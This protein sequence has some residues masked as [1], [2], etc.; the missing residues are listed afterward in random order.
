MT[1]HMM[2]TAAALGIAAAASIPADAQTLERRVSGIS[3]GVVEFNFPS[4]EGVCGDGR[5]W[6]R[7]DG[8]MWHGSVSDATRAQPCERGPV[9]VVLTRAES[10]VVRVQTFAGPLSSEP[11]ATNLG[12]VSAS[13]GA[14]F[15]LSIAERLD[16]RP[17]RDVILPAALA[18]GAAITPR[19]IAIARDPNRARELRRSAISWLPRRVQEPG[20]VGGRELARALADIARDET[21]QQQVRQQAMSSL[22][23]LDAG[24]GYDALESIAENAND[25]WLAREATGVI[26]NSGD[27]RSREF[28]RRVAGSS[29]S[30][31]EARVSALRGLGGGYGTAK[32]AEFLRGLYPRLNGERMRDAALEGIASIG[33]RTNAS[34]LLDIARNADESIRHRKRAIELA[35]RAGIR[36][37]ELGTLYDAV[38]DAE[39]RAVVIAALARDGSRPAVDKLLS[40]AR[41]DS[42]VSQ[43]RRAISALTKFEDQRVKDAL[44]D[45][46]ER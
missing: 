2:R 26:A 41:S 4:R 27:P 10:E 29:S 18:D 22:L 43:R 25:P 45:L 37:S 11:G 6:M 44:K 24:A 32:D 20:G 35:D 9:R 40:I 33:G 42:Q 1:S 46:V 3:N 30:P 36:A 21:D 23:R 14:Q 8:D 5:Y 39:L 12:A 13:E 7:V 15:L 34:W 38:Q 19:L 16:A 17:G 28:L 31:D